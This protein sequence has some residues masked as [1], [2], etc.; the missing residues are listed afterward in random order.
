MWVY[1]LARALHPSRSGC[2]LWMKPMKYL[3]PASAELRPLGTGLAG[4][5]GRLEGVCGGRLAV[6]SGLVAGESW[7]VEVLVELDGRVGASDWDWGTPGLL[8]G[9]EGVLNGAG[10]WEL[11]GVDVEEV[12]GVPG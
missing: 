7:L 1:R 4:A 12:D 9:W 8:W 11:A 5:W 2:R 3:L 6:R 10:G